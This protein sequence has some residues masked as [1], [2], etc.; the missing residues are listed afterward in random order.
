MTEYHGVGIQSYVDTENGTENER[1]VVN[2]V[3][4]RG[5]LD[6]LD[7]RVRQLD[8]NRSQYMRRLI[9]TDLATA[10]KQ[11]HDNPTLVAS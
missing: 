4:P 10:E 2:V 5:L 8:F 3:L 11:T 7:A 1:R 6:Q 9:R